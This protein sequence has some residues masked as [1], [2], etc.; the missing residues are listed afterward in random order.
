MEITNKRIAHTNDSTLGILF[1]E[2]HPFGFV[3]EDEPRIVKVKGET[4]IPSGRYRLQINNDLTPLTKKYIQRFP[5]FERH[6]ELKN[7]PNFSNV[8]IHVGNTDDDTEGC[9]VIGF[10]ASINNEE[11]INERSV[12][13]YKEFYENVYPLLK[14]GEEVYYT[15]NDE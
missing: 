5:W 9:Q 8:Y 7:V 3:I 14:R 4:R 15:I 12:D 10:K 1:I 13:C 11:F 6:I 2:Q